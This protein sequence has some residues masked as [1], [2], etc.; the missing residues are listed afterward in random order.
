LG[1]IWK[2]N[3]KVAESFRYVAPGI[4][5]GLYSG[6]LQFPAGCPGWVKAAI[7]R[8]SPGGEGKGMHL[9]VKP[10]SMDQFTIEARSFLPGGESFRYSIVGNDFQKNLTLQAFAERLVK[11]GKVWDGIQMQSAR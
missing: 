2:S 9:V 1:K 10:G 6:S 4:P 5:A 7:L 3:V 8:Y 11:A